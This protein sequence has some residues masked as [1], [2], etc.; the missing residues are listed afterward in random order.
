MWPAINRLLTVVAVAGKRQGK[1]LG[2]VLPLLNLLED[3]FCYDDVPPGSN[4]S[5]D[6]NEVLNIVLAML[7][8]LMLRLDRRHSVRFFW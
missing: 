5:N 2:W 6:G 7:R 1:T 8:F 4:V 3:N